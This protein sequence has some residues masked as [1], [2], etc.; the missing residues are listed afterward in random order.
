M[1]VQDNR[2]VG[3]DSVGLTLEGYRKLLLFRF[4]RVEPTYHIPNVV[5]KAPP[6]VN[7]MV[8]EPQGNKRWQDERST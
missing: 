5:A 4:Y 7:D 3:D 2:E 1:V 6:S 8:S